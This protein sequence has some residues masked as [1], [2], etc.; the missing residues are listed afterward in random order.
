MNT[1]TALRYGWLAVAAAVLLVRDVIPW[2]R[3]A[4][5][6][7]HEYPPCVACERR[8]RFVMKRD[9]FRCLCG[10]EYRLV[11]STISFAVH[12]AAG[13]SRRGALGVWAPWGLQPVEVTREHRALVEEWIANAKHAEAQP[14]EH[15]A[16]SS[17]SRWLFLGLLALVSAM[18]WLALGYAAV[19]FG[20]VPLRW[21]ATVAAM[22]LPALYVALP[23]LG[24]AGWTGLR[25]RTIA[26]SEIR[27]VHVHGSVKIVARDGE[28]IRLVPSHF[29]GKDAIPG[30]VVRRVPDDARIYVR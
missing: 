5:S 26:W 8:D 7:S 11:G 24:V 29:A 18:Q 14:L 1:P 30:Y 25:T 20:V 28:E 9:S 12:G 2:L 19:H 27:A 15:A 23:I 21:V 17:W 13:E 6:R 3:S 22:T 10:V 4:A 16:R